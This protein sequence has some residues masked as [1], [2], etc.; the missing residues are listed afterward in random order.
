MQR[1]QTS[2]LTQETNQALLTIRQSQLNYYTSFH[3]TFGGQAALIGGFVYSGM[4]G[5]II[6]DDIDPAF[7]YLFWIFSAICMSA[8]LHCVF[9]TILLQVLGPGLALSGPVGSITKAT[10]GLNKETNQVMVAYFIMCLSFALSTLSSFWVVMDKSGA[11]ACS[12]VFFISFYFWGKYTFRIFN[13]FSYDSIKQ[14][15]D[16]FDEDNR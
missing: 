7:H 14:H 3:I 15:D 2:V 1:A 4:T 11:S 9:T 6:A 5:I 13:R 12:V 16:M 10:T 8:A